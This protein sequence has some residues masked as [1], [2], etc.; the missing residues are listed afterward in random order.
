[1]FVLISICLKS[2]VT[3]GAAHI[4]FSIQFI[5]VFEQTV[6]N[7]KEEILSCLG[8]RMEWFWRKPLIRNNLYERGSYFGRSKS[9]STHGWN[10]HL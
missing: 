8:I 9:D 6:K 5:L 7:F 2:I 3:L 10:I 4:N 1:M